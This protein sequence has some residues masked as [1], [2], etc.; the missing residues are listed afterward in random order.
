[1]YNFFLKKLKLYLLQMSSIIFSNIIKRLN[2]KQP[3]YFQQKKIHTFHQNHKLP[4]KL[5]KSCIENNFL[6]VEY[7]YPI[8]RKMST[9]PES[10][11]SEGLP[12]KTL[13]F[14]PKNGQEKKN[15]AILVLQEW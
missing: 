15:S 1:M 5:F 11:V 8:T 9:K 7:N 14:L 4:N 2:F 12:F 3:I 6:K 13:R 10:E